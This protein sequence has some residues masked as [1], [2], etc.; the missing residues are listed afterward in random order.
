MPNYG[1]LNPSEDDM[2]IV[3]AKDHSKDGIDATNHIL[4][5]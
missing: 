5:F 4:C 1:G 3:L 2:G